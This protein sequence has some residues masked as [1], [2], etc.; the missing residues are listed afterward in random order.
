MALRSR[1]LEARHGQQGRPLGDRRDFHR[2]GVIPGLFL[3]KTFYG[4]KN[5]P[6]EQGQA[7][8]VLEPKAHLLSED[9]RWTF[10]P[11]VPVPIG[12]REQRREV[13]HWTIRE[14]QSEI[15]SGVIYDDAWGFEGH[16]PGP[17]LRVRS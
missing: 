4:Q 16:V 9:A 1:A 5:E 10:A 14:A 11:D 12:R 6:K 3:G 7:Q 17:L 15:A 8:L 2:F 13:V